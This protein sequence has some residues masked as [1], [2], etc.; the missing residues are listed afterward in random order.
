M[1]K[2]SG[3]N[4]FLSMKLC[5]FFTPYFGGVLVLVMLSPVVL[6]IAVVMA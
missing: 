6:H 3:G 5:Q 1:T 4:F 2:N